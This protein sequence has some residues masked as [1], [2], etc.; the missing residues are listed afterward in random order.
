MLWDITFQNKVTQRDVTNL[1]REKGRAIS[2][3]PLHIS[4]FFSLTLCSPRIE[5][6][7][8]LTREASKFKLYPPNLMSS[9]FFSIKCKSKIDWLIRFSAQ[10]VGSRVNCGYL[11]DHNRISSY[12]ETGLEN[13]SE[14]KQ[15]F[16]E[17]L[18]SHSSL[19]NDWKRNNWPAVMFP[20]TVTFSWV[21]WTKIGLKI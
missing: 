12:G 14:S 4:D 10:L 16:P 17:E 18:S 8:C 7:R 11:D 3:F 6:P 9:A 2:D 13:P 19:R 15:I 5:P 20:K 1:G 21:R